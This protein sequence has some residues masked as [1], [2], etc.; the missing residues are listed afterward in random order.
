MGGVPEGPT[1][2]FRARPRRRGCFVLEQPWLSAAARPAWPR[3]PWFPGTTLAGMRRHW[4]DTAEAGTGRRGLPAEVCARPPSWD[5]RRA[6][7]RCT[8]YRAA[9]GSCLPRPRPSAC[10]ACARSSLNPP[11]SARPRSAPDNPG[12]RTESPGAGLARKPRLEARCWG[13]RTLEVCNFIKKT[14]T[15][16]IQE[17]NPIPAVARDAG[18]AAPSP[19]EAVS[20][21]LRAR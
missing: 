12:G 16:P 21:A 14:K 15:K 2:C 20:R 8:C 13:S 19:R 6:W 9:G 7:G 3:R 1:V 10:T 18:G 11:V 4:S 5:H 17:G